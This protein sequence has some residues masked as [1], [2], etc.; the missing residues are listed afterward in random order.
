[1]VR[2]IHQTLDRLLARGRMGAAARRRV[3]G[4]VLDATA[5]HAPVEKTSRGCR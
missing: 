3:L 2:R 1:M 5:P 4:K